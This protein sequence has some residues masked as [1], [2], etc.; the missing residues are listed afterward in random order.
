MIDTCHERAAEKTGQEEK[1]RLLAGV[2]PIKQRYFHQNV[3]PVAG[4]RD[5]VDF[6]LDTL[7]HLKKKDVPGAGRVLS[8]AFGNDP[9]WLKVFEGVPWLE[10]RFGTFFLTP[11]R[12]CL[13]YGK[14]YGTSPELEG[15]AGL[16]P[17]SSSEM[18]VWRIISSGALWSAMK[19]GARVAKRLVVIDRVIKPD[20]NRM[21]KGREYLYLFILGVLPECQGKGF[22]GKI[23]HALSEA[24]D[25]A[26]LPVYLETET[27]E[28]VRMYEKYGFTV[29]RKIMLDVLEVP[30]WEMVREPR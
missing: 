6:H 11:V 25:G 22:G 17:G 8:R 19:I 9:L 2:V 27:E 12:F 28:N 14:L 21:M 24:A 3:S 18:T 7:Y 30:M 1:I 23:L 26:V 5:A 15:V 13:K 10:E 16:V 4:R 20:R 29:V